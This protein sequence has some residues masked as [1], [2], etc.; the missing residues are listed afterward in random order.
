[1]PLAGVIVG[2]VDGQFVI[3][4][5]RDQVEKSDIYLVVAGTKDAI[6]MVEAEANEVPEETILEAIMFGH[7]EIKK[8][9]AVQ[10]EFTAQA[11]KPK[12][13]VQLH[14]VDETVDRQVREYAQSRLVE[15]IKI[16]DK[17]ERQVAIDSIQ[18]EAVE[19]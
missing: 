13:D 8:A 3:N 6:M 7:E 9:V 16:V 5:G 18:G 1:G 2:R 15:A 17:Q 10:E 19:H 4:P 11:G 14:A 12:M